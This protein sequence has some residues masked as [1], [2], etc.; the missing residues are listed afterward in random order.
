MIFATILASDFPKTDTALLIGNG[1][2][3]RVRRDRHR[4]DAAKG[5]VGRGPVAVYS[6]GWE[7]N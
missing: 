7:V 1:Q 2:L 3:L 4:S 5:C 6:A